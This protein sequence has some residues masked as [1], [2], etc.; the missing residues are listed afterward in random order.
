ML[1]IV[2]TWFRALLY[3]YN[4]Y[5]IPWISKSLPIDYNE[6]IK[7]YIKENTLIKLLQSKTLALDMMIW[8]NYY[9]VGRIYF[10]V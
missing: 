5:T 9:T 6:I 3:K 1:N 10:K 7:I 2:L 4:Y 8:L